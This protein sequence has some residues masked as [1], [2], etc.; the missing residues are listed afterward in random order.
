MPIRRRPL[1]ERVCRVL[2]RLRGEPADILFEGKPK[3][4]SYRGHAREV[5]EGSGIVAFVGMV[6]DAAADPAMPEGVRGNLAGA[7]AAFEGQDSQQGAPPAPL[8]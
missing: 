8:K 2:C 1:I 6:R 3:W 7:L 4:E 5:I